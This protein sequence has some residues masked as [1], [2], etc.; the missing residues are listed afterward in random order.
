MQSNVISRLE[1]AQ[2][3]IDNGRPDLALSTLGGQWPQL[4]DAEASVL[5]GESYR[6]QGYFRKAIACYRRGR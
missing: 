2:N 4:F 5:R 6:D 1:K 3:A